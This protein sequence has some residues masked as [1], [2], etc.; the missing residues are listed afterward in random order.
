MI[1]MTTKER[2]AAE[3]TARRV[4]LLIPDVI[5]IHLIKK[6]MHRHGRFTGRGRP[7]QPMAVGA[8]ARIGAI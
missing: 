2:K 8:E 3:L 4:L 5:A 1:P 6:G 7:F